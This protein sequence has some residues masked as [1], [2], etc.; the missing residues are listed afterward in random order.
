MKK[1]KLL[2]MSIILCSSVLFSSNVFAKASAIEVNGKDGKIYQYDYSTLK[3]SAVAYALNGANNSGAKLYYDFLTRK[4]SIKAFY[5]DVRKAFVDFNT[6]A[7]EAVNAEISSKSFDLNGFMDDTST[8]TITISPIQVSTDDS[9]N[10]TTTQATSVTPA[11]DM[12]TLTLNTT[13]V[14]YTTIA[15]FNLNVSDPQ[16]YTVTVK[17]LDATLNASTGTFGVAI[18]GTLSTSDFATSDFVVTNTNSTNT[19]TAT[20]TSTTTSSIIKIDDINATVNQNDS[21][22]LPNTV[23]ATLSDGTVEQVPVTWDNQVDTS[24][25]GTFT[26]NGTVDG[27][28]GTVTLTLTVDDAQNTGNSQ[29]TNG[30]FPLLSDVP[31]PTVA[32]AEYKISENKKVVYYYYDPSTTPK[33][34]FSN[35]ESLLKSDGWKYF[36]SMRGEEDRQTVYYIKDGNVVYITNIDDHP[37]IGGNIH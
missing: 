17:G 22:S 5:D 25:V 26:F 13:A 31:Q 35:Y 14:P 16:D 6:V 18:D 15:T 11:V 34:F 28:S 4:S 9:G 27:Y 2:I 24:Q 36:G 1:T 33:D 37:S 19:S 32:Y 3:T 20:T 30:Y 21:Y 12:T 7:K 10:V 29:Q 23:Q 8:P